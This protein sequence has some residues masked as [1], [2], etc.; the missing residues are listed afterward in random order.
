MSEV[1]TLEPILRDS[2][3]DQEEQVSAEKTE[4]NKKEKDVGIVK[5][6]ITGDSKVLRYNLM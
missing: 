1:Y 6:G 5:K 2:E 3:H 4:E